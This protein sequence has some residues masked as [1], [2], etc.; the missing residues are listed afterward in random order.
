M[1]LEVELFDDTVKNIREMT[2][3]SSGYVEN[4]L[5]TFIIQNLKEIFI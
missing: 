5:V 1:T 4:F 2:E 3:N